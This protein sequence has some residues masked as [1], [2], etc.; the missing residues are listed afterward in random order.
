MFFG[1]V[2]QPSFLQGWM[3]THPPLS[4]RIRRM[5][6]QSVAPVSVPTASIATPNEL[7]NAGAMGLDPTPH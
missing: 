5:T 7:A 6:G 4:E 1:A 2:F 3:A